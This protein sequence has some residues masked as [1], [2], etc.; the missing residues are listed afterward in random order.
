MKIARIVSSESHVQYVARVIDALDA[1]V[2]PAAGDYGFGQFVG[3]PVDE[4]TE[5]VGVI[6]D[7]VLVNPEYSNFGPRLSPQAEVATFSPDFLAEQ[8]V[9]LKILLL[10]GSES[11]LRVRHGVPRRVI[12]PGHDVY[13]LDASA[14]RDFHVDSRDGLQVHYYSQILAHTGQ[15]ALPL[16]EAIIAQIA[17][18]CDE[19]D[20]K[21][22]EVLKQSLLWQRTMTGMRL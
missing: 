7:T 15:F 14:V 4:E 17:P 13:R 18:A 11:G 6:Y 20:R 19:S 9:L 22:L 2:P 12:P 3:V 21:R 5:I 10:G 1:E 16:L 8:G